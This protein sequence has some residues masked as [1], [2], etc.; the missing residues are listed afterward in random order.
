[1]SDFKLIEKEVEGALS[2]EAVELVDFRCHRHGGKTVLRFFVDKHGGVTLADCE[3]LSKRIGAVLDA[4]DAVHYAYSLEV[5]SPGL[6]RVLKKEK[7]FK[8]FA[9]HRVKLRLREP[10]EGRRKFSG[11]LRGFE[12]GRVVLENDG[13]SVRL[14]LGGI[15]EAR[16]DPDVR[17]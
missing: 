1:M 5:S 15:E 8:R 16:L 14:E 7:D 17:I 9:G 11:Y 4:L 10:L 12:E 6:D 13:K 2:S 3:H